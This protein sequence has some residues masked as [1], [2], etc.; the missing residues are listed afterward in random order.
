MLWCLDQVARTLEM[1]EESIMATMADAPTSDAHPP[2][3]DLLNVN[4]MN[5]DDSFIP[6]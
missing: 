1:D 3:Q 4:G 6:Q 5:L 2:V